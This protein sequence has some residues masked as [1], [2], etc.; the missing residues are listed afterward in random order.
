MRE[1][2]AEEVVGG[3][4]VE[5]E[6]DIVGRRPQLALRVVQGQRA[7]VEERG[8]AGTDDD[9]GYRRRVGQHAEILSEIVL[10][11]EVGRYRE[12]LVRQLQRQHTVEGIGAHLVVGSAGQHIPAPVIQLQGI[13]AHRLLISIGAELLVSHQQP[14]VGLD[15]GDDH[16]QQMPAGRHRLQHQAVLHRGAVGQQAVDGER[17]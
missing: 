6:V 15:G 17:R 2:L 16:R 9:M 11:R 10:R 5:R 4:D 1:Q 12:R 13:G 14:A 3:T 7:Q 8:A